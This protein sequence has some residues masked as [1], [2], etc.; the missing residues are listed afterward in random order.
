MPEYRKTRNRGRGWRGVL[1]LHRPSLQISSSPRHAYT[2]DGTSE[3]RQG[4]ARW[5]VPAPKTSQNTVDI[6]NHQPL[7]PL[8]GRQRTSP[9]SSSSQRMPRTPTRRLPEWSIVAPSVSPLPRFP[10]S[11]STPSFQF[12]DL[13]VKKIARD[14]VSPPQPPRK[15]VP[16][17]EQ[18]FMRQ[19]SVSTSTTAATTTTPCSLN[20]SPSRHSSSMQ[21]CQEE[22]EVDIQG[23]G[24]MVMALV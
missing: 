11:R 18:R 22:V 3:S 15:V 24:K 21:R 12:D 20:P 9:R 19:N 2:R 1:V 13:F 23:A 4:R 5:E 17:T 6:V 8:H 10:R 14:V 16:L 7:W